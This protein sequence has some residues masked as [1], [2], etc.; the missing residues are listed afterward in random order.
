MYNAINRAMTYELLVL[1]AIKNADV[2]PSCFI[3]DLEREV[4]DIGL[5]FN[6]V[7]PAPDERLALK[8]LQDSELGQ[9]LRKS[10]KEHNARI[11]RVHGNLI[12]RRVTDQ[13]LDETYEGV[14]RLPWSLATVST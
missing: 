10:K 8:I 11:M 4:L 7:G 1:A 13:M 2:G 6:V 14:V 9:I 12:L 3:D 5:D